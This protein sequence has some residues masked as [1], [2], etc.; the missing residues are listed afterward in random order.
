MIP[1]LVGVAAGEAP[2]VL[3]GARVDAPVRVTIVALEAAFF[4]L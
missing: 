3:L 1:S 2:G 4:G